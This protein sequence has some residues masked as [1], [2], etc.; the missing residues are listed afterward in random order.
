MV[1]L[2]R[3]KE[4]KEILNRVY[5]KNL[6]LDQVSEIANNLVGY[7]GLLARLEQKIN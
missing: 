1:S 4:L 2:K 5:D 6:N 3:I 7:F